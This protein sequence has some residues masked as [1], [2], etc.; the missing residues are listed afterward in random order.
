M[1]MA[2]PTENPA[3]ADLL[4]GICLSCLANSTGGML[5]PKRFKTGSSPRMTLLPP[6]AS[7]KAGMM[8]LSVLKI[9][10]IRTRI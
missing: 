3:T 7:R 1:V 9:Q 5:K 6:I 2:M 4:R 10:P 8:M